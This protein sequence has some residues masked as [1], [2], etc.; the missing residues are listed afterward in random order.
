MFAVLCTTDVT[1]SVFQPVP[2]QK[3]VKP[4]LKWVGGK[5]QLMPE[6][7]SR[8]PVDV[9][10][11]AWS[12]TYYEPFLGGGALFFELKARGLLRSGVRLNDL[13]GELINLYQQLRTNWAA[14]LHELEILSLFNNESDFLEI[15]GWDR[16]KDWAVVPVAQKA[17]RFIFLNRTAFNGLYRVNKK[18]LFN[19]SFGRYK[20]PGF[21]NASLL[22]DCSDE[23]Q[24]ASIHSMDFEAV[25]AGARA[26]D[27]VYLDPPYIP[28]SATAGFELYTAGGFD[29]G[30]QQRLARVCA[31]L[32]RRGV[33]W[34][35]S[36]SS[37]ELA[38]NLFSETG[39]GRH[40][41]M[42]PASRSINCNGYARKNKVDELLAWNYRRAS[43]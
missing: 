35:L 22:A 8:L 30:A 9:L 27:F 37:A 20:S 43:R 24:T 41:A 17:A 26:G 12:G 1:Q 42:V 2:N 25:L 14:V 21:P 13:N 3:Q 32:T 40:H 23:L 29:L 33:R 19:T 39:C 38:I 15:R 36:N 34:L 6:L 10:D 18:G 11:P 7:V 16:R 4:F 5:R 28:L 31:D